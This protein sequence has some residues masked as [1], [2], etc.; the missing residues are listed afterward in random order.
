MPMNVGE[1]L[2]HH[3]QDRPLEFRGKI[4]DLLRNPDPGNEARAP[5]EALGEVA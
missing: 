2:L 1:S 5:G 4:V 3:T